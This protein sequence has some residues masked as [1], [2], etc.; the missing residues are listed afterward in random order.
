[1]ACVAG[2]AAL[3]LVFVVVTS[4]STW[5]NQY[6]QRP[7][8]RLFNGCGPAR[9]MCTGVKKCVSLYRLCDGRDDCGDN[10]DEENCPLE[11]EGG[12][13]GSFTG[14]ILRLTGCGLGRKMCTGVKKCVSLSKL[15]D[16]RDDC[17]DNSDE[18]NCPS[19]GEGGSNTGHTPRFTGCGLGRKMFTGVKKFGNARHSKL[20]ER[21]V[22]KQTGDESRYTVTQELAE[23][24]GRRVF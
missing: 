6:E 14:H 13:G 23:W 22:S 2:L 8:V 16:G 18:E 24:P 11:G 19:G 12:E 21:S 17:G 7:A 15:C 10:S 1:M 9:K 5:S 20:V 4:F 3:S